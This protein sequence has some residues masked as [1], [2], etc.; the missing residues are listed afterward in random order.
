VKNNT[1]STILG[2]S[3]EVLFF[4]NLWIFLYTSLLTVFRFIYKPI[5]TDQF[6][7]LGVYPESFEIPLYLI[8]TCCFVASIFFLHKTTKKTISSQ[9][10]FAKVIIFFVLVC[11]FISRLGEYPLSEARDAFGF[12]FFSFI[13]LLV[14]FFILVEVIILEQ[15]RKTVLRSSLLYFAIFIGILVATF[16][17][18]FVI[19]GVDFSFFYGPILEIANGKTIYSQVTS[20]YGFVSILFFSLLYKLQLLTLPGL[21][22]VI[23]IL[24]SIQYLFCFYLINKQSK[25]L[26]FSLIGLFS[27][28]TVNYFTV[29]VIPTDYPQSGPLRWLPLIIPLI[30]FYKTKSITSFRLILSI[31]LLSLWMI[32]TGIELVCAYI[33][34]LLILSLKK[35]VTIRDVIRS[36]LVLFVSVIA[37][38]IVINIFHFILNYEPINPILIFTKLRQYARFG[39]GMLPIEPINFFWILLLFYFAIISDFFRSKQISHSNLLSVFTGNVALFAGLY[40][41]GRS[42]PAELYTISLLI[43]FM[44]FL[45]LGGF[46]AGFTSKKV[47]VIIYAVCFVFFIVIPVYFR[48]DTLAQSIH[49]RLQRAKL[50]NIFIPELDAVLV[51]KYA[52]EIALIQKE[53]PEKQVVIISGDDTYLLYVAK[54]HSM[55]ADNSLVTILTKDD[56]AFSV[57]EAS[58]VCPQKIAGECRLFKSCPQTTLF[59][60]AFHTW[61]PIVLEYLQKKCNTVYKATQC[62]DALCIAQKTKQ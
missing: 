41:V 2:F 13:Y 12:S 57:Q 29:R 47:K 35:S 18:R 60:K 20:Q 46:V 4:T 32:D 1:L 10:V 23:W 25:S 21:P 51:K 15:F 52:K 22:V 48:Q 17:P 9:S 59:S 53:L 49:T 50:G 3:I 31:A 61:Q 40:Y 33:L 37:L 6:L 5:P 16:P 54:K 58:R 24:L 36:V 30:I 14:A 28:L 55:L 39:F 45:F 34:T 11:L 56:L 38:F 7:T 44:I 62:T 42:H 8:L 26:A 19:S 43:I 27:I